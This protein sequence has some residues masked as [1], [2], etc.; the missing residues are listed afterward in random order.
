MLPWIQ[1]AHTVDLAEWHLYCRLDSLSSLLLPFLL[2][3]AN[4]DGLGIIAYFHLIRLLY[5]GNLQCY[6]LCSPHPL[7]LLFIW[8]IFLS[9]EC[10][11]PTEVARLEY[12]R[13]QLPC[14]VANGKT[15]AHSQPFAPPF[16]KKTFSSW[17]E[18]VGSFASWPWMSRLLCGICLTEQAN[19]RALPTIERHFST[20]WW[21]A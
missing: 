5:D 1:Q 14:K 6:H 2:A 13:C 17:F 21:T 9:L 19:A 4:R 20:V 3:A 10:K 15:V 7:F 18:T 12:V 11:S 8:C 16:K